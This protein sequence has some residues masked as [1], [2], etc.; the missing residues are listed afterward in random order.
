MLLYTLPFALVYVG[1]ALGLRGLVRGAER[2]SSCI[3]AGTQKV[4]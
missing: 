2:R 4:Q 1:G 3:S